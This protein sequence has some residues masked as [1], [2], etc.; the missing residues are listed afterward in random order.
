MAQVLIIGASRGIGAEFVRQHLAAGDRVVA[1]ARDEGALARLRASGAGAIRLDVA[2]MVSIAGLAWQLDGHQFDRVVHV[3]GLYGPRTQ[4]LQPPSETDFDAVMHANV[5]GPMRVI[6]QILDALAPGARIGLLSSRMGSLAL[7]ANAAGWLYRA[8]KAALNS[9]MKDIALSLDGRALCVSLHP[10]W[11]RT[12][13]GGDAAEIDVQTSVAGMRRTL[14]EL[15]PAHS[16]GFFN[17]DG[18]PLPW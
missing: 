9:V 16:G 6:P 8:S 15:T 1:T 5:L 3:A 10:G 18:S 12:D 17:H 11:V 4:G 2:D 14:D 13:M 7:R